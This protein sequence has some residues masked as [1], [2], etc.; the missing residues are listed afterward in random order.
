M[1]PPWKGDSPTG[2]SG[3]KVGLGIDATAVPAVPVLVPFA[4]AFGHHHPL[5]P[6]PDQPPMGVQ[7]LMGG[8]KYD[9]KIFQMSQC[10]ASG[11]RFV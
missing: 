7:G 2:I 11:T 10:T 3:N 4:V 5:L 8:L 1:P 9:D 6:T